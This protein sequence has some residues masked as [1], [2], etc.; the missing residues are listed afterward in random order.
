[1]KWI[2][3][4]IIALAVLVI[5]RRLNREQRIS[6]EG[7]FAAPTPIPLPTGGIDQWSGRA[8]MPFDDFYTRYYASAKLDRDFVRKT[9]D[10]I[11]KAGGV[12]ADKIRPEDRIA[13]FPKKNLARTVG[14]IQK[15]ISG[16]LG[17]ALQQ[18][19]VDP[20]TFQIQTVDD[21]LRHL[22]IHK[23]ALAAHKPNDGEPDKDAYPWS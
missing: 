20:S 1:M 3:L 19:G 6:P 22:D 15:I 10:F 8:A 14:F 2:L 21:I 23:E 13:D 5:F 17:N 12:P 9:L 7:S 11:S 4:I 18:R 16:P